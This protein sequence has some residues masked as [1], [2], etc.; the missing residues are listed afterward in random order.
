MARVLGRLRLVH[1]SRDQHA[2]IKSLLLRLDILLGDAGLAHRLDF[3]TSINRREC[4]KLFLLCLLRSD[5]IF[6]AHW[7]LLNRRRIG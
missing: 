1:E 3:L 2:V 6:V 5:A 4:F 7:V